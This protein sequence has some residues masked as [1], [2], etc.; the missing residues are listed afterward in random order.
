MRLD[1]EGEEENDDDE[2]GRGYV[3]SKASAPVD[4]KP[5]EICGVYAGGVVEGEEVVVAEVD[6][7]EVDVD[8][9]EEDEE[10][11]CDEEK[12]IFVRWVTLS[13]WDVEW[14]FQVTFSSCGGEVS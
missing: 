4:E 10:G 13:R 14:S 5:I 3:E 9:E 6:G 2:Q 1:D 11:E 7:E 12:Y 8:G